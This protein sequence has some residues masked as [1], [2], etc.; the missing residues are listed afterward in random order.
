MDGNI[1]LTK[2]KVPLYKHQFDALDKMSNGK[3]LCG[4]VGSGKSRTSLAYYIL[5]DLGIGK[6][7]SD[8]SI[9]FSIEFDF[10]ELDG[11][12]DSG[13]KKR[14]LVIITTARKR[15]TLDWEEEAMP[16]GLSYNDA[17]PVEILVDSWNNVSKYVGIK[18]S[19]FIFDEQRLVTMGTWAKAFLKIVKSNRWILLSATPGDSYNDYL[20]LFLAHGF[21]KNKTEFNREHIV[22]SRFSKYP[23]IE[24]YVGTARLERYRKELLVPM[25]ARR[26]TEQIHKNIRCEFDKDMYKTIYKDRWDPYEQCPIEDAG[27]MCLLLRKL[28]NTDP[29]RFENLWRIFLIHHKIIVF[30]NF[31]IELEMLRDFLNEKSV[32]FSEWNGHCHESIPDT[33]EWVYLVQYSAGNEGW[34]CILTNAMV[35]FSQNYSYKVMVQAAGR[36]DRIN[37]PYTDLFYYHLV[38]TAT[39]DKAILCAL[40]K[41]RN[42][43]ESSFAKF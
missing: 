42:F 22:F 1:T 23:K 6:K 9:G 13:F 8:S 24:R 11:Y 31:N 17:S 39:I 28:V 26:V 4:G 29:S 43:N 20:T 16:F 18:D 15:D 25:P 34:N 19:F 27:K 35:F 14:K 32:A 10:K 38:S 33:D 3:V 30:Y 36:I 7:N 5:K 40:K 12:G 2:F 37:T 41:K 21:Y